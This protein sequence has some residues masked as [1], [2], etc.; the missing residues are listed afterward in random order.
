MVVLQNDDFYFNC[1]IKQKDHRENS[2][3]DELLASCNVEV[4]G[5]SCTY[6]CHIRCNP[7]AFSTEPDCYLCLCVLL[8]KKTDLKKKNTL[9]ILLQGMTYFP[10]FWL[11]N[12]II[13]GI[14]QSRNTPNIFH[15]CVSVT[16]YNKLSSFYQ[17]IHTMKLC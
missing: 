3:M 6:W 17:F 14:H 11:P 8:V 1:A 12:A 4:Y 5:N 10:Y 13:Y 9:G 15:S 2:V 16:I 7:Q